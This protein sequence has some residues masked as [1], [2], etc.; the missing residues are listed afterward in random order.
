MNRVVNWLR[1]AEAQLDA[2]GRPAWIAAMVLGFILIWPIGLAIL[3]YMIWSNRMSCGKSH[4]NW[5]RQS[6]RNTGNTAF[7][8]YREE[9]LQ[10]LEEEQSAFEGFLKRLRQAKDKAEFDQFMADRRNAAASEA[11]ASAAPTGGG[12]P[13][14]A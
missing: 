11:P 5:R 4:R 1:Q 7:D 9:T 12:A 3:F 14:L 10:R 2:W 8:Q 6:G 13:A